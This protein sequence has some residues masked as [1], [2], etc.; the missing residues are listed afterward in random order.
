MGLHS[1]RAIALRG[2]PGLLGALGGAI[3]GV[4]TGGPLGAISGAI[5][6]FAGKQPTVATLPGPGQIPRPGGAIGT[7]IPITRVPGVTGILQRAAP[8]GATGYQVELGGPGM[9]APSGYHLNKTGYW[10]S[11]G[12]VPPKSKYVRNRS[13]NVSNGRAN[14]RALRRLEAWDKADRKRRKVLKAIAR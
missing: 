1:Q 10:T 12:Y 3:K 6:G 11:Q 13:R 4:L 7:S 2:D 14:M 8:F 5:S 9:G